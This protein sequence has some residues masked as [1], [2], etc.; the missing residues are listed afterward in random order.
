MLEKT[1]AI[2][3]TGALP[4]LEELSVPEGETRAKTNVKRF[5][6]LAMILGAALFLLA[7][8]LI[9]LKARQP[10]EDATQNAAT[11]AKPAYAEKNAVVES[12]SIEGAKALIR[13]KEN[14]QEER[15]KREK[16]A[17]EKEAEEALK[18]AGITAAAPAASPTTTAPL[19]VVKE[20]TP[21]ER[22]MRTPVLLPVSGSPAP[23]LKGQ[24]SGRRADGAG[25]DAGGSGA[26]NEE[27]RQ[28]E[29]EA[30]MR[31]LGISTAGNSSGGATGSAGALSFGASGGGLGA[32]L[33]STSLPAVAAGRLLNLD[34]L[35][36]KGTTI[37]CAM[38]TGINTQLPGF[39]L[40]NVISDVYSA[41]GKTLLI[42]RGATLF[43]EQQSQLQ[44]GQAR[45][46]VVWS[47]VD[48]PSGVT[49]DIESPGTD[50]MG[51]SGVPGIVD[52]HFFERFGAAI[53]LTIVKDFSKAAADRYSERS[54]STVNFG[55]DSGD[56]LES[57][58]SEALKD[59]IGIPPNLIVKP[60]TVVHVLVARDV[61]FESVYA[62]VD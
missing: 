39:V 24:Q 49:A 40:C 46:F 45:T 28:R 11:V 37:P 57:M 60:G 2:E 15:R 16:E 48:N 35:L 31:A 7:A 33:R 21:E 5:T 6:L 30:R 61:T 62:I 18:L 19:E 25:T 13:Q 4:T 23:A 27:A 42:E 44:K 14:E 50:S 29:L 22:A 17:A 20:E 12:D 9:W 41:N 3:D 53:L 38:K 10:Q 32:R 51:Y 8:L 34:Y 43:G 58:A 59:S 52:R 36:K 56:D 1:M 54:G 26:S 55:G 47:R